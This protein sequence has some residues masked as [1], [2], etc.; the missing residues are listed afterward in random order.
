[1]FCPHSK[2]FLGPPLV[3]RGGKDQVVVDWWP[4]KR[5]SLQRLLQRRGSPEREAERSSAGVRR[6]GIFYIVRDSVEG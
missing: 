4:T 3:G 1:M 6:L 2:F 5:W